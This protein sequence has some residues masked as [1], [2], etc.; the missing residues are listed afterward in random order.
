MTRLTQ[1]PYT[2][3]LTEEDMSILR[4]NMYWPKSPLSYTRWLSRKITMHTKKQENAS[5]NDEKKINQKIIHCK[6]KEQLTWEHSKRHHLKSNTKEK[7]SQN[8]NKKQNY[9]LETVELLQRGQAM[10]VWRLVKKSVTE[11]HILYD[12]ISWNVP[13]RQIHRNRKWIS[14]CLRL[15]WQRE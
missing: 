11:D 10:T 1:T 15:R 7:V 14:G 3:S 6:R 8:K 4:H 12:F 5:H 2:K 13:N 9:T